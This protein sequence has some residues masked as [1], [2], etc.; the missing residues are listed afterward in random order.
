MEAR[1]FGVADDIPGDVAPRAGDEVDDPGGQAAPLQQLHIVVVGQGRGPGGLPHGHVAHDGRG[2]GQVAADGGEVEGGHGADEAVQGPV[3]LPVPDAVH[4]LRLL[5]EDLLGLPHAEAEEVRQ[6]GDVD[7]RLEHGLRL[8]QHG[9][10]VEDLPVGAGNHVGG[11][12][13]DGGAVL[14]GHGLPGVPGGQGRVHGLLQLLLPGH[15]AL[16]DDVPVVMGHGDLDGLLRPDLPAAD[17]EGDL[18][19]LGRLPDQLLLQRRPLRA[20]G[21]IPQKGIVGGLGDGKIRVGHVLFP[22]CRPIRN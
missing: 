17:D 8:A 16:G 5:F 20:A 2:R 13:E 6:L 11:L 7:L 1:H 19:H 15:A 18:D 3:V 10:G 9:G 22:P 12:E 4:A 14:P 21:Q